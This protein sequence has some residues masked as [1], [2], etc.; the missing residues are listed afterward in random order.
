VF[1]HWFV[2]KWLAPLLVVGAAGIL[3]IAILIPKGDDPASPNQVIEAVVPANGDEVLSQVD[4]GVDLIEGYTA[5]LSINGVSIPEDELRRV[6]GLGQIYFRPDEGKVIES[7]R[8][9][10]NCARILYW[11]LS[12]GRQAASSYQWCFTAS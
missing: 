4:V 6:D 1:E 7:L 10:T 12:Q 2:K 5:E 8:P 9:E 3:A 11:P